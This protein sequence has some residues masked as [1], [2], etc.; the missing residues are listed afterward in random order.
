M[1]N[2][3]TARRRQIVKE[4]GRLF[5]LYG[6]KKTSLEDIS[7]AIGLGK[8][9]LYYYFKSKEELYQAVIRCEREMLIGRLK[10]EINRHSS[11][12]RKLHVYIITRMNG[13]K[14]LI[15]LYKLARGSSQEVL[16]LIEEERRLFFKT[17][18]KLVLDILKEGIKKNIFHIADPECS[19]I[20]IIASMRGLESTIRLYEGRQFR[21]ADYESM[22]NT[23]FYGILKP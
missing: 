2:S 6:S 15:N 14:E 5:A 19:A 10:K 8:A 20:T 9:S 3:K 11:A 18:K 22:L 23:L 12:Q 7:E 17:E 1:G 16:P 21:P 4:A 13:I